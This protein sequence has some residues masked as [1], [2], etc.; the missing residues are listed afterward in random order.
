MLISQYNLSVRE[1]EENDFK[2]I[3]DYFLKADK[4]FLLSLGV[5]ISKLPTEEEWLKLLS[6][7]YQKSIENKNFYYVIWLMNNKAVG[8]SNINKLI[9]GEE[10]YMHL[11]MWHTDKRQ[12]GFGVEFIKMSLPYFFVNFK[13]KRLYC[14]PYALN[15]APNKTLRKSEFDFIE[16]YETIPGWL[17]FHQAVN[18]WCMDFKKY[19]LLFS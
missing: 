1:I 5:D 16:Q 10:A 11:H 8:H 12:K 2:S 7:E 3:I 17:N 15:N 6:T 19:Q 18:K 9:F 4:N 14:E 13:L